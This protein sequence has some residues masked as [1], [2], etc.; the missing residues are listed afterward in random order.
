MHTDPKR[1]SVDSPFGAA[2]VPWHR[3]S[4]AIPKLSNE[5]FKVTGVQS[6]VFYGINKARNPAPLLINEEFVA[7]VKLLAL[8]EKRPGA[9]HAKLGIAFTKNGSDKPVFVAEYMKIWIAG[10]EASS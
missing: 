4:A 2:V 8:E 3:L 5:A 10:S 6:E 9:Y 1:C 7:S